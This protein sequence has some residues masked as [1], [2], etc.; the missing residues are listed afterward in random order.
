MTKPEWRMTNEVR[1]SNDEEGLRRRSS[2]FRWGLVI[3]SALVILISAFLLLLCGCKKKKAPV[4]A[5]AEATVVLKPTLITEAT[6]F[7]LT[8][9]V[10][11]DVEFCVSSVQGRK[12]VE[13]LTSSRWWQEMMTLVNDKT[14]TVDSAA[15]PVVE[16]AFVAFG[17]ESAKGVVMLR[18]LNDLYNETAYRGMMSG[19]VLKGLGTQFDAAKM[20][21]AAL[22]DA[23]VLEALILWLERFEMP[24]VMIGVASPEPEKVLQKMGNELRLSEWLGDAPQSRI[25]TTHGEQ[26]TVH[27][28]AMDSILTVE[29]RR[30]WM[31][32]LAKTVPLMPEMRDRVARGLDVLARKK[33]VLALG[34]GKER[35]YVAVAK[36][37]EQVR[38]A[39]AVEDSVLSRPEMR[40]L[41][42]NAQKSLGVV[43]CW[44]GVFLN[45]LQSDEPFQP[46]VRGLLAGLQSEAMFAGV[47][48]RLEPV[49]VE[50][51]LAER[52]C[53]RADF[54]NGALVA[55][56][57][58][59]LQ[60]EWAGGMSEA[61]VAALSKPSAFSSLLDDESV[62]LGVSGQST[63]SGAGRGYFEAWMK[64]AHAVAKELVQAGVGGENAAEVLKM[65]EQAILPAMVDV[66]DGTKTIW[67]KG[68]GA[69]GA[70]IVD[71]GGKMPVL[72]GL[73]PGGQDV[74]LPRVALLHEMKNR[75]LIGLSWQNMEP[76]L[77]R[78]MKSVPT[79]QPLELPQAM[80]RERERVTSFSY[81]LPF[82]SEDLKPCV[83]LTEKWFMAG[84]SRGQQAQFEKN[85]SQPGSALWPGMR[86][87]M[88]F[89]K[90]REFLRLFA[91]VRGQGGT[92]VS[93]LKKTV[94]WL[95][96]LEVMEMRL[97]GDG[98]AGRGA[99]SW[100]MHD[101]VSYD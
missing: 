5:K 66:Y 35:A 32:S 100:K 53:Y 87:K 76:A 94:E 26:I 63:A 80:R 52:A 89:T 61:S 98:G 75:E 19:G 8:G 40:A 55:W 21:E 58:G 7:G 56:W 36:S 85:L 84:T 9:R 59:G 72:P 101:I 49:M 79:P 48:R 23:Q 96:P 97:W 24:P 28:V 15:W 64:T 73:P 3:R 51:A 50:L 65:A 11:A 99:M 38:L 95:E 88:S 42:A 25:V 14:P 83:S 74:P 37:T 81:P 47:A 82:E 6:R 4:K 44:D 54:S 46:M 18:Q 39:N 30:E 62:V 57:D 93:G 43:A 1:S 86:V 29:R 60:M 68:L 45:A 90:L 20:L 41:D 91:V 34:L 16:E 33:W 31:E 27:E 17:K 22:R 13:A 92:D 10:P 71:V 69:D 12:H 70:F 67:Q 78:L 2:G 77:Q